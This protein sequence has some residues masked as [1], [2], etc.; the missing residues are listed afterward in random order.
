[1]KDLHLH[2]SGGT[3]HTLLFEILN[4]SGKKIKTKS[5]RQFAKTLTMNPNRIKN[6]NDYL[7]INHIIDETQSSPRAIELSVYDTFKNSFL[8]GC[9]Y[10]ELRWNPYK[11]SQD[12]RIDLDRLIVAARSGFEKA[13]SIFGIDG[14]MIF[15]LGRDCSEEQNESIFKKAI[16]YSRRG[17]VGLDA[18]GPESKVPLKPE[19]E[20][21][22]KIA[23]A[24]G[25]TTTIHCGEPF[26]DQ[27]EDTLATVLEKYKPKRIGHGVQIYRFPKLMK[28]A[29]SMG[30]IFEICISSNLMTRVV[31]SKREF[32]DIFKAF[33]DHQ[34]KYV[35][36]TDATFPL[37]TN[38][39]REH[40]I[41]KNIM[42]YS[43]S[44]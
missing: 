41:H 3:S 36:C 27:V 14:S 1:M 38:I 39:A 34:I 4:E 13:N 24:V 30:V 11:R 40:E 35:I 37:N 23:N 18:A 32:F 29:S 21:Y 26:Y 44:V 17:V 22:Y 6:M 20:Q 12:F 15:C 25:L 19:F 9:N 16:Q 43:Q 2:L 5:Y 28:L 8:S 10:L 33:E 42:N 7:E 31:N